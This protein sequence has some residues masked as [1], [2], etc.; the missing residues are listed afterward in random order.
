MTYLVAIIETEREVVNFK[1][2]IFLE[3]C[4]LVLSLL[5]SCDTSTIVQFF[6]FAAVCFLSLLHKQDLLKHLVIKVDTKYYCQPKFELPTI[7]T[8]LLRKF[9]RIFYVLLG[10]HSYGL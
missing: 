1:L 7:K 10:V 4:H 8:K 6:N 3:G 2:R 9:Q 5:R